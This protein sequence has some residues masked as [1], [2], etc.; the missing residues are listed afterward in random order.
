MS[1]IYNDLQEAL[2]RALRVTRMIRTRGVLVVV[3]GLAVTVAAP[4]ATAHK[5][6]TP[7]AGRQNAYSSA[8]LQPTVST[9]GPENPAQESQ[10]S[11]TAQLQRPLPSQQ[12]GA[13][14]LR[15]S[16]EDGK[17][18]I[19]AEN[20]MLSDVLS[21]VRAQT[22]ADIELPPGASA[23][24]IWAQLGPGPARIVLATLLDS[25]KLDYVIRASE[26]DPQSIQSILLILRD[27]TAT[28]VVPGKPGTSI[29]QPPRSA[30]RR[31]PQSNPG[32]AESSGLENSASPESSASPEGAQTDQ[33]PPSADQPPPSA[34]QPLTQPDQQTSP[35][36][37]EADANKPAIRSSEQMIQD[38]QRMYEQRKQ[39]QQQTRK[40]PAPAPPPAPS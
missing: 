27:K 23:Q 15:V 22:G 17:L 26:T 6:Q 29:G 25:T 35:A 2:G 14:Q 36:T 30:I 38:L 16:Y 40:P 11:M 1:K 33:L 24:R 37:P 5:R 39:M 4:A 20:S 8:L 18:T 21:A 7:V 9:A 19:I 10:G 28:I 3:C 34:D 12:A 13:N 31:S 32:A